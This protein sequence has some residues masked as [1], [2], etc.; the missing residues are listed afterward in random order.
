MNFFIVKYISLKEIKVLPEQ[1]MTSLQVMQPFN[2]YTITD[3]FPASFRL[4]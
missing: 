1:G 2:Y 4:S 3:L